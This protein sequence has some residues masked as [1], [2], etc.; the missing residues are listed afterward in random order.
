M[1]K[2]MATAPAVTEAGTAMAAGITIRIIPAIPSRFII[3][4]ATPTGIDGHTIACEGIDTPIA[5]VDG[6]IIT[7]GKTSGI[8]SRSS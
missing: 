8:A 2:D 3:R 7:T 5:T 1:D 6:I 4:P